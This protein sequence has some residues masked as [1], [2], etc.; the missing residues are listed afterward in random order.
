MKQQS[1]VTLIELMITVSVVAILAA[2]VYP[3]YKNHMTRTRRSDAQVALMRVAAAQEKYYSDCAY[4]ARTLTSTPR[5][6]G[7]AAGN[8]DTHLAYG[9]SQSPEGHYTLSITAAG[10]NTQGACSGAGASF[11]CGFTA[12]ATPVAGAA[13]AG[14]GALRLDALGNKQWDKAGNNSFS[15][16]WTDR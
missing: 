4:Y 15:A 7:T 11:Q 8:T 9:T 1:G 2:I 12:V 3:S 13:Q 10:G 16:K 5:Q 14:N 6:C